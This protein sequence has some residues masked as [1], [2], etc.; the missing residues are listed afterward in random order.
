MKLINKIKDI[1]PVNLYYKIFKLLI[2]ALI[3]V[4]FELLGIGLVLPVITLVTTGNFEVNLGLGIDKNLN[5]FFSRLDSSELIVIPLLILLLVYTIKGVYICTS[6]R[7][8]F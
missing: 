8:I 2:F 7:T 5:S 4:F 6:C 1:I 3:G